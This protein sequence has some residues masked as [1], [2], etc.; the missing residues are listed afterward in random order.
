CEQFVDEWWL[1]GYMKANKRR[2]LRLH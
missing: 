1:E 2:K